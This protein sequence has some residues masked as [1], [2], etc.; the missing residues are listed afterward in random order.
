MLIYNTL[1]EW[2]E[3]KDENNEELSTNKK[4]AVVRFAQ[5]GINNLLLETIKR[6]IT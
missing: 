5:T 3:Y 2:S 6:D 4:G 1:F